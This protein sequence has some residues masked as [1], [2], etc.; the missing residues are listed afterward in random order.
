MRKRIIIDANSTGTMMYWT[1][2]FSIF[3][4]M[5]RKKFGFDIAPAD[6]FDSF[7]RVTAGQDLIF[8]V[9]KHF[10]FGFVLYSKLQYLS[11]GAKK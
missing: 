7:K 1:D 2:R 3:L 6:T 4:H 11:C 9:S 5:V 8:P 10:I